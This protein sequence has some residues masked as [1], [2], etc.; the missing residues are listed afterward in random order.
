MDDK[1]T[2]KVEGHCEDRLGQTKTAAMIDQ[3]NLGQGFELG[4]GIGCGN[5]S[6]E[7]LTTERL[8]A[9]LTAIIEVLVNT[10]H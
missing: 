5:S 1:Q 4:I 9:A 8:D 6:E 7:E 3:M 2:I 10:I